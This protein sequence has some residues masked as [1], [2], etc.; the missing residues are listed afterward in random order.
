M[1][2]DRCSALLS[3]WQQQQQRGEEGGGGG[4]A[5]KARQ[6]LDAAMQVLRDQD[7]VRHSPGKLL[8]PLCHIPR[9]LPRAALVERKRGVPW[10]GVP[11]GVQAITRALAAL[12]RA[13]A[14]RDAAQ[15]RA[16]AAQQAAAALEQRLAAARRESDALGDEVRHLRAL[17]QRDHLVEERRLVAPLLRCARE[18]RSPSLAGGEEREE[19]DEDERGGVL[20]VASFSEGGWATPLSH[21]AG[22]AYDGGDAA[23]P[24]D[25]PHHHHQGPGAQHHQ[26]HQHP[27]GGGQPL[28]SGA[29]PRSVSTPPARQ[30]WAAVPPRTG[31]SPRDILQMQAAS[32]A[33]AADHL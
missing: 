27:A 32:A 7:K 15:Q 18:E 11:A 14:Q 31:P 25:V 28:G 12:R 10:G 17:S 23:G 29:R 24:P 2:Q 6:E 5:T 16:A 30:R 26:H 13:E 8:P 1:V 22:E 19:E 20:A 4:E 21:H 33:A 3:R 9:A